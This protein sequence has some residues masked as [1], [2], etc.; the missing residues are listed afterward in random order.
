MASKGGTSTSLHIWYLVSP[1][2]VKHP[3][4][5][6]IHLRQHMREPMAWDSFPLCAQQEQ[7]ML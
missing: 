5:E 4:A 1:S 3:I 6:A 2:F 7:S